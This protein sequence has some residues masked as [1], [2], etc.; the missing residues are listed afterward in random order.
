M[1]AESPIV[2]GV[3]AL[4]GLFAGLASL[5][6]IGGGLIM[7]LRLSLT[8]LPSPLAVASRLTK[9]VLVSTGLAEIIAP[10]LLV[11]GVYI[12]YRFVRG[13]VDPKPLW[14]LSYQQERWRLLGLSLLGGV[15]LFA[16]G[17]IRLLTSSERDWGRV[18]YALCGFALSVIVALVAL[19]VRYAIVNR[20]APT[21]NNL[22]TVVFL[23][24]FWSLIALP[25]YVS[26]AS[27]KPFDDVLICRPDGQVLKQGFFIGET[28]DRVYLGEKVEGKRRLLILPMDHVGEIFV[29]EDA[30]KTECDAVAG[31]EPS[32]N[33]LVPD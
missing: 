7:T 25:V 16:P 5:I 12:G 19:H 14:T 24:V 4:F 13:S 15:F 9:E 8:R 28:D 21:F 10:M 6:Y 20:F 33:S 31:E 17:G 3:T 22:R 29:G 18:G 2:K 1:D 27:A 32:T 30:G 23:A 11:I 26:L